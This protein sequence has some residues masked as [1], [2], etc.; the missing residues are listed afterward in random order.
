ML[1]PQALSQK[2]FKKR[3]LLNS[4]RMFKRITNITFHATNDVERKYIENTFGKAVRIRKALNI[5][6]HYLYTNSIEKK[7]G[8]LRLLS[9]SLISPMKN[10]KLVLQSL[11]QC[12]GEVVYDIVGAVK[13]KAYWKEC[14]GLIDKLPANVKVNYHGEQLPENLEP[15]L[16]NTH[17]LVMPSKS[18]NYGHAIVEV[19]SKGRPVLTSFNTPWND[20]QIHL[21]GTNINAEVNE[22]AAALDFFLKLNQEEYNIYSKGARQ[23]FEKFLNVEQILE[24]Y[25]QLFD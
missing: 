11:L 2:V 24:Q 13:D 25:D 3:V 16:T 9:I 14:L 17:L 12:R 6:Q 22:I 8:C 19:L 7:T 18:E 1:H 4:L 15:Y 20:L 23:Y 5:P 21:A 10:H